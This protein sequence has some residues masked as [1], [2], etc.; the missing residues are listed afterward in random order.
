MIKNFLR[1]LIAI[2]REP[3]FGR[4]VSSMTVMTV[5]SISPFV[6]I[7]L[8]ISKAYGKL[9]EYV[10]RLR[11]I[12]LEFLTTGVGEEVFEGM[13]EAVANLRAD[14]L[15]SVAFLFLLVISIR[16]IHEVDVSVKTIWGDRFKKPLWRRLINY[17]ILLFAGP[18]VLSVVIGLL[19]VGALSFL[20]IFFGGRVL[21]PLLLIGLF[22]IYYLG[23]NKRPRVEYAF[24]GA[25]LASGL[26]IGAQKVFTFSSRNLLR[27]NEIYGS[28]AILPLFL[29]WIMIVW[30]I[31]LFGVSLTKALQEARQDTPGAAV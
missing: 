8:S 2:L 22:L 13:N 23:P 31:F 18:L 5:L 15:A 12:L 21:L 24:A 3:Q 28:L 6:A 16:L 1:E 25:F 19:D 20:K 26:L 7:L 9:G 30:Y 11:P 27:H 17:W 14:T 4:L 29:I 10:E